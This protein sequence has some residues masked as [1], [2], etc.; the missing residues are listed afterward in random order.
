MRFIYR[1]CTVRYR[2]NGDSIL[3][4][5]RCINLFKLC[6]HCH[7]IRRHGKLRLIYR[8][9]YTLVLRLINKEAARFQT[10]ASTRCCSDLYRIA[11]SCLRFIYREC[12]VQHRCNCD[13][14]FC[15]RRCIDFFKLSSYCY[16]I[17][18][19]GKLHL[20]YGH[21]YTLVLRL[22]NRE[23]ARFQTIASIRCYGDLYRIALSCL[24]FIYR[25]RTV[26]HR[27]NGDSILCCRWCIDFFKLSCYCY[28]IRGHC[29]LPTGNGSNFACVL[30]FVIR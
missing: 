11:L 5:G 30:R 12:T 9:E 28:S 24:R 7:C 13:S 18:R 6:S 17:S 22:I 20:I 3:C 15:C 4:C 1:E 26:Q 2:C 27:C 19:H 14:I 16:S 10:I 23:A 25:E 21:E 29:K 8:H